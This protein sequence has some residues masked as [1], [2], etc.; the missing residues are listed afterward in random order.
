M[1]LWYFYFLNLFLNSCIKI[2][3][4]NFLKNLSVL[5]YFRSKMEIALNVESDSPPTLEASN[6]FS[7]KKQ[8]DDASNDDSPD[9]EA[10]FFRSLSMNY[11]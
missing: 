1:K 11:I 8:S 2:L 5:N 4:L 7:D 3:V 6:C 9:L 10:S